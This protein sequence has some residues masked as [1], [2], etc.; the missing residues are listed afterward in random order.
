MRYTFRI[1]T[2]KIYQALNDYR[3]VNRDQVPNKEEVFSRLH[4]DIN[5]IKC[6]KL[7]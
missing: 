2:K 3:K 4:N 1:N 6:Y 7:E 5:V